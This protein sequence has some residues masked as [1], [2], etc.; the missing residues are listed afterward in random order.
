MT[1]DGLVVLEICDTEVTQH[2]RAFET[3]SFVQRDNLR[4]VFTLRQLTG[5]RHYHRRARVTFR[6][7]LSKKHVIE[8]AAIDA[9]DKQH[10]VTVGRL[11]EL[12][13]RQRRQPRVSF[14]FRQHLILMTGRGRPRP[15]DVNRGNNARKQRQHHG[16]LYQYGLTE[17]AGMHHGD[18]TFGIELTQ[19]HQQTKEQA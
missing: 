12:P 11:L 13:L 10:G 1:N 2:S 9:F 5:I 18:F 7:Q 6:A 16:C 15:H 8:A 3:R 4:A 17:A 19:G 14:C